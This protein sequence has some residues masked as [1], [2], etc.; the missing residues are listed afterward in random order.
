MRLTGTSSFLPLSVRGTSGHGVDRVRDVARRD[1]GAQACVDRRTQ[2]VVHLRARPRHHEQQ[3]H[4]V[5]PQAARVDDQRL[6]DLRQILHHGV[7]LRRA[8][9]HPP[10]VERRVRPAVDHATLAR[11]GDLDPVAVAPHA[12]ELV[13]IASRANRLP[14]GSFQKKNG[15][16]WVRRGQDEF[17]DLP[18]MGFPPRRP[19]LRCA[20]RA[21]GIGVRRHVRAASGWKA[22]TPCKRRSRRS[23]SRRVRLF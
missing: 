9:A 14:S 1:V 20:R 7:K 15:H 18:I 6:R 11:R 4:A 17:A 12:G 8:H 3:Q 10:A 13:I 16:R 21:P 5:A 2:P 19:R 23:S 22:R